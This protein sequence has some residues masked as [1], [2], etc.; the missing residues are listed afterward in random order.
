MKKCLL[1]TIAIVYSIALSY[2]QY[3]TKDIFQKDE[4]VW[5]GLDFS[6]SK[7][8]GQFDQGAGAAPV[9]GYDL[10]TKYF[11]GWNMLVLKEQPKYDLKRA[12]RKNNVFYDLT[13]VE[14]SNSTVD[15]DNLFTYNT[16][17]FDKPDSVV[18]GIVASYSKG[19]KKE[20]IGCVFIVESFSKVSAVAFYYVTLFDIRTNKVLLTKRI[21]AKPRGIGVR[22]YWAGSIL[23]AL[24][25]IGG[26]EYLQ[27]K[28]ELGSN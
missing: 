22:N 11:L 3:T 1:L 10:K 26:N 5:Y 25:E 9:S 21:L 14:K 17:M 15:P 6:K 4:I 27:W 18:N 28:K 16:Y 23:Y 19:E 7:M 8:V 20:G 2:A 12:F 13:A 24:E